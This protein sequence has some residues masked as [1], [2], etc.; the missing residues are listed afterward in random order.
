MRESLLA[1]YDQELRFI[2]KMVEEGRQAFVICPLVEVSA[3]I[4]AK[5]AVQEYERLRRDEFPDLRLGLLHGRMSGS[6]KEATMRA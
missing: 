6:E 2:R 1:Y 3:A 5:A 4:E